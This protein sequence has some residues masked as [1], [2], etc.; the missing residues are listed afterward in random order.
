M[1]SH[2]FD[3][4]MKTI[5][6]ARENGIENV[7]SLFLGMGAKRVVLFSDKGLEA[8]GGVDT[9]VGIFNR[10]KDVSLAGIFTAIE[11]DAACQN[12]ND[13]TA[14]MRSCGADAILAVGGGSVIDASK[15]VKYA[16][17]RGLSDIRGDI[18]GGGRLEVWPDSQGFAIPHI[19][20]P[21]TAGT[22]AEASPIAVFFNE[23]ENVKA[24]LVVSG[25]EADIAILDPCMTTG[26]PKG[27]TRSTAFDSLTHAVEAL[28][29]PL[30]NSFTDAYAMQ[31]TRLIIDNLPR[32]LEAPGDTAARAALLQASTMAISAFYSSLGGIPIHNC[33]HAFGAVGHIPHG[34][35]NTVLMPF[36]IDALPEFYQP[37]I[38]KLASALGVMPGADD[39]QTLASVVAFLKS[40]QD[41][42]GADTT[43]S[44]RALDDNQ[45]KQIMET[46]KKDMAYQFYAISEEKI[47]QIV[48]RV[49]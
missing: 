38:G 43:F 2:S 28:A 47:A 7:P 30:S 23:E 11:P 35:A 10:Q 26:L 36:V 9:F 29:S 8:V 22:G 49:A 48:N 6:H 4:Q 39:G 21:T 33:A 15:G 34:D 27:L 16:L 14:Y 17:D 32:A 37:K 42:I 1:Q 46:V 41:R 19:A 40:F 5:V 25:L 3:Y 45:K 24:S 44:A 20:V 13:A 31:A 18:A 12:I